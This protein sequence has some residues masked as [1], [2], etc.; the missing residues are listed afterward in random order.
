M[1][2]QGAGKENSEST[3]ASYNKKLITPRASYQDMRGWLVPVAF[4]LITLNLR[5]L[6]L[7][8]YLQT[9]PRDIS[10]TKETAFP[11]SLQQYYYY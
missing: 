11:L 6:A 10:R 3:K 7:S 8:L 5:L 2:N 9:L 1:T 4:A